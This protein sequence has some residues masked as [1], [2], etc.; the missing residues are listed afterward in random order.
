MISVFSHT[1][2]LRRS[3]ASIHFLLFFSI[4]EKETSILLYPIQQTWNYNEC[5]NLFMSRV[6][7]LKYFF[8]CYCKWF[9]IIP[10]PWI[11]K[12]FTF[13]WDGDRKN[14]VIF[15]HVRVIKIC[16]VMRQ[17]MGR[18]NW[19]GTTTWMFFLLKHPDIVCEE[20]LFEFLD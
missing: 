13:Y 2:E 6:L 8:F 15:W 17:N 7:C 3:V 9:F 18:K 16:I 4:I 19:K 1:V 10:H 11:Q 20:K 14:V 5:Y 12:S